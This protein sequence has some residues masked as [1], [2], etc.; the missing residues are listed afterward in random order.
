M[1]FSLIVLVRETG[2][3]SLIVE[4]MTGEITAFFDE[5]MKKKLGD[6]HNDEKPEG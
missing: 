5:N 1:N 6:V 4:D 3:N 2:M